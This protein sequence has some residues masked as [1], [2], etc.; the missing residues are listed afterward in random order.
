MADPADLV[1]NGSFELNG[2]LGQINGTIS[3]AT[4]WTRTILNNPES[5]GFAFIMDNTADSVG[6]PSIYT[7]G[8][9][10][11]VKIWGPGSGSNN[12]FTGSPDG[13][14]FM[15]LDGD[16]GRSSISQTITGLTLGQQYELSVQWAIGQLTDVNGDFWAQLDISFGSE[17]ISTGQVNVPN[18]G[19]RNWETLTNTFTATSSS[20]TLSFVP[21]GMP[22][23]PPVIM[24]DGISLNAVPVPEPSTYILGGMATMILGYLSWKKQNRKSR[25]LA[26]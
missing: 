18:A 15:V 13:G 20:Q 9:G 1:S 19:F 22:G 8:S 4:D 2:G 11:N 6:A 5:E 16:Y 14:Y 24:L 26:V 21:S 3:Y 12:G 23:L 7:P 25:R 17:S 10:Q